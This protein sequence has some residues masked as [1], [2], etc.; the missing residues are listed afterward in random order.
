M[1]DQLV[2]PNLRQYHRIAEKIEAALGPGFYVHD[3]LLDQENDN[4]LLS[5]TGFKF[6]DATYSNHM[7]EVTGIR[8][9]LTGVIDAKSYA[10]YAAS[11]FVAYCAAKGFI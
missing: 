10:A 1:R 3:L 11:V 7:M 6:Y 4:V 5:E 2:M 9:I 8:G